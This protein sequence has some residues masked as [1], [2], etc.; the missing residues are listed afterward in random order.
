MSPAETS[1]QS[2]IP[3]SANLF[4]EG[5]HGSFLSRAVQDHY[6]CP[7]EFLR[8][9]LSEPLS[10]SQG[11]FSCGS[12]T[13]YGHHRQAIP[14]LGPKATLYDV[15]DDIVV[16][17]ASLKLPFN[18]TEVIENL[19]FERYTL[20]PRSDASKILKK[21][22]YCFRPLMGVAVRSTF[23]RFRARNWRQASFPKWPVDTTVQDL[24]ETLLRLTM[25]ANKIA[26]MPFIWFWPQGARGCVTMTHDVETE[27]GRAFCRELMDLNDSFGIK[28]SFQIIPEERYEVSS[29]F[30]E[31]IRSRGFEVAVHDLNHDGHLYDSEAEFAR[32]ARKINEY[33][34][35]WGAKGFR[36]GALY[37]N[38]DWFQLLDVSYDMSIPNVGHLDP[39]SGGCCTVMPFFVRNQIEIP[40]TAIQDYT[41]FHIIQDNSIELWKRQ[42]ESIVAK[43]GLT[44]FIVH[45]D[46]IL[47]PA[48]RS[49]YLNLLGYLRDLKSRDNIWFARPGEIAQWWRDRTQMRLKRAGDTW[50]VEGP[51]SENARVAFAALDGEGLMY[52][53][54]E[55]STVTN[56]H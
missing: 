42:T 41:L 4:A 39:Q 32:R 1:L 29:E 21:I 9:E 16:G 7:D 22:Y 30:L 26:K 3:L 25:R 50:K 44:S 8:W 52:E 6:R 27:V 11:Y 34:A 31:D 14:R 54:P 13:C 53:L 49:V 43:N 35:A 55:T 10:P 15:L 19:Q 56:M 36:A 51:G 45:P 24:C 40:V 48:A 18:P 17:D 28:S 33:V 5:K 46:Y 47:E 38:P 23:Q 12:Q 2:R 37:R 20:G